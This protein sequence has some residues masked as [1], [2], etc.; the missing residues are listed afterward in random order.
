MHIENYIRVI[1]LF[2]MLLYYEFENKLK[3]NCI[4]NAIKAH[5]KGVYKWEADLVY[6]LGKS[7]WLFLVYKI[8]CAEIS[9]VNLAHEQIYGTL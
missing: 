1:S 8:R 9:Y 7:Y 6:I 4:V 3:I 2:I 5:N